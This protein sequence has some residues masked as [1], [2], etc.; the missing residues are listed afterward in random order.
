MSCRTNKNRCNYKKIMIN[1][2]VFLNIILFI[3]TLEL[4]YLV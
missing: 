4:K 1:N 2:Q 3:E